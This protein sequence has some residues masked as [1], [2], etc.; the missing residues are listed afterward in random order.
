MTQLQALQPAI[1]RW[2]G[3]VPEAENFG[4]IYF[5]R[6]NG[7]E[8]SRYVF[9]D[10]NRLR[11]RF[12]TLPSGSSFVIGETGF[13][14]GLNFLL[15]WQLW[16]Q[17]APG[18]AQLFFIST[19]LHPL[20][21]RDLRRAL[22]AWPE[23]ASLA[24][25][26][27]AQY[28]SLVPGFHWLRFPEARVTLLLLLGDANDTLPQ[29]RDSQHQDFTGN[30]WSVDAW[31]LDGFAPAK[32]P[33]L[34]QQTLLQSV[35]ALS[36][37]GTTLATF[38]AAGQVRRE[39]Q[40]QGFLV[41]KISG[42][43]SKREMIVAQLANQAAQETACDTTPW[44]LHPTPHQIPDHVIVT[45]AGLAGCHIARALAE[46]G[47]RVTVLEKHANPAEEA[48]GNP[49]GALHTKLSGNSAALAQ[50]GLS[51]FQYATRH[52]QQPHLE[53][54]FHR[55]G[56]LQLSDAG[57]ITGTTQDFF[58][59]TPEL[60]QPL[61]ATQASAAAGIGL[62]RG[63]DW[64]P[65]AGWAEPQ[66]VCRQLL[67]HPGIVVRYDTAIADLQRIDN[68]WQ[69]LDPQKK[70]IASAAH[71]VV[72]CANQSAVFAETAWLPLRPVRGQITYLPATHNSKKLQCVLCN[73]GY[74]TPAHSAQSTEKIHCAGASFIPGDS[75]CTLRDT[76]QQ[77]NLRLLAG[78][79][80]PLA[81]EWQDLPLQGRA[82]LRSTTP[83]HLPLV[84]A[85][86]DRNHFLDTYSA[87]QY[88]AKSV[89]GRTGNHVEGLWMF[90]GFGGRGLCYIPLAAE[91]LASQLL[92]QPRPVARDMQMALAPGRFIIRELIRRKK[93][94]HP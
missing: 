77:H 25:T 56:L 58:Q 49:Q 32:N 54:H 41:E 90:A 3:D 83:D 88:N 80:V 27:L 89:I 78:I 33:Q 44:L 59:Q 81:S 9:L 86:P 53:N 8:E 26:L 79:S 5:S 68:A 29:L 94:E 20:T 17:S 10:G 60:L 35:G 34:W 67:D 51:S 37:P 15:A 64:L 39:L 4:D 28:P 66:A 85:L 11:E 82:A 57:K 84:G 48:S 16:Q 23:L 2:C 36:K 62:D 18:N 50:F 21:H 55:C 6:E 73:E 69:L 70:R 74:I 31:F 75:D 72:A 38:T 7:L 46:R 42:Y 40:A 71:V 45:G 43:G 30:P 24:E 87:L 52:Y 93:T 92:H 91:L 63:G 22:S 76:E 13:G 61:D 14:T 47:I 12:L 19:E 65:Q 1:L